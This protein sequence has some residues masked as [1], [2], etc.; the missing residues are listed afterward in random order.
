M[1]VSKRERSGA[2]RRVGRC[3]RRT[4][5]PLS[6][7]GQWQELEAGL[8]P[9]WGDARL[10][11]TVESVPELGRVTSLLG[12]AQ[13]LRSEPDSVSFRVARDGSGPSSEAVRRLLGR[14]DGERLHGSLVVVS[15]SAAPAVET[16]APA[17]GLAESWTAALAT[18]PGDW[19][20]LL[21]EIELGSSDYLER[22]A[23]HLGPVNPRRIG[24]GSVLQFRSAR[25]FGYGASPG[26]VGRCLQRCDDDG[27]R[28]GVRVLRAL[29][30]TRPVATQGPSWLIDGRTV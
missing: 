16:A 22:A 5:S 10:R 3:D 7:V 6:L 11:L 24:A 25:R 27:I 13:P 4:G 23:L 20:D 2:N 21:G 12:P 19:S 29:S 8:G 15:S 1:Y 30:D 18:L 14:L 9:G 17:A 28:G 26:M